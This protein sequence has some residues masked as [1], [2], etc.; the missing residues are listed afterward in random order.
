MNSKEIRV[1][2]LQ[3]DTT[4]YR[5]GKQNDQRDAIRALIEEQKNK[6][7]NLAKDVMDNGLSPLETILVISDPDDRRRHTVVEGN[8]RVA[9]MKLVS[10]PDLAADTTW[11]NAFKRLHKN[12]PGQVPKKI[13]CAVANSK[14]EEAFLWI[15]RRHDTGLKGAG[16]ESWSTIAQYRAHAAQGRSAPEFDALE[17]TLAHGKLDPDVEERVNGQDFPITNLARLLDSAYVTERLELDRGETY[18][19]T[20]ANKKWV[21]SM[22]REFITIISREE[23]NGQKFGVKD[24]YDSAAQKKFFNKLESKHPKP[25]RSARRWAI[26]ADT[27]VADGEP[28][29]QR[30]KKL[31]RPTSERKKL[32]LK[33]TDVRPPMG[34]AND[35]LHELQRLEVENYRNAVSVLF[36]VFLEFSVEEYMTRSA[37]PGITSADKLYQKIK[38]VTKHMEDNGILSHKDLISANKVAN[39]PNSVL[40]TQ[41]LNAYVHNQNFYPSASELKTSWD[42]LE[43]FI[44]KLWHG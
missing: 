19:T 33:S 42:N 20:T 24:I 14:K 29:I 12:A 26:N 16:L 1:T 7:V 15:Q 8:R 17:F 9:A 38:A 36:R 18:L 5:T 30:K 4:N 23:H 35:I 34:R 13:R 22:L 21:L 3:L 32:V 10:Q 39:D 40:S 25:E 6:L 37:V 41:Q 44:V 43:P 2:D 27:T 28:N 31:N 11:H